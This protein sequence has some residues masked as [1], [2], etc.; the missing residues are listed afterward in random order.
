[1]FVPNENSDHTADNGTDLFND[2]EDPGLVV[3]V[4]VG[5]DT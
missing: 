1:M 4:S 3:V 2:G 5:S